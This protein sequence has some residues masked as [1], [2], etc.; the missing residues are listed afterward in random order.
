VDSTSAEAKRRFAGGEAGPLWVR[1]DR[2]TAGYGRRGRAWESLAGNLAATLLLPLQGRLPE[3]APAAYAF[4]AALAVRDACAE[5]GA[6][7]R[8]LSLKWPNDVLYR[9]GKL[10][11]LLLELVAEG[12]R[13]ALLLGIG[14]NLAAAPEVEAY[15]TAALGERAPAPDAFLALLD[16]RLLARLGQWR[17]DGFGALR[18]AFEVAA[19]G[20]HGEVTVRLPDGTVTGLAQC[21]GE[22]GALIVVTEAGPRRFAAGDVFFPGDA[23]KQRV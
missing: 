4:A 1:A 21:L 3:E 2:Q 13:R 15:E 9:G 22:D 5:A 17:T 10:A 14:V 19:T 16:A 12:D 7:L 18:D 11:G 6:S 8:D 20:L 23:S